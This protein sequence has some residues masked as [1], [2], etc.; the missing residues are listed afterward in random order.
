M[1]LSELN[2]LELYRELLIKLDTKEYDD[3][4]DYQKGLK[5]ILNHLFDLERLDFK[6]IINNIK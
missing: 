2:K 3:L 1:N 6:S 5:D 4:T